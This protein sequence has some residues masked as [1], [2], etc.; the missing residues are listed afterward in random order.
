[1][2]LGCLYFEGMDERFGG[3]GNRKMINRFVREWGYGEVVFFL[4]EDV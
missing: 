3:M 1:M 2:F 4:G